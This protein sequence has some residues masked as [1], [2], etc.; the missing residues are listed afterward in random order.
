MDWKVVL[1]YKDYVPYTWQPSNIILIQYKKCLT[2]I[3][4]IFPSFYQGYLQN[5]PLHEVFQVLHN[6]CW[7]WPLFLTYQMDWNVVVKHKD[8][9]QYTWHPSNTILIHY[10]QCLTTISCVSSSFYQGCLQ[11][12][13]LS[14][15]VQ[16]LFWTV[17]LTSQMDWN[18]EVKYKDYI[19]Y[20]L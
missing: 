18:V 2:T 5:Q 17:F 11:K 7:F 20:T 9:I 16:V 12:K 13:P 10:N 3:S 19:Q 14:D 1:K 4:G 8:C 6:H 15:V